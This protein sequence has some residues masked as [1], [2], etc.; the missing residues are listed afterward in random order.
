MPPPLGRACALPAW[1]Q[2]AARAAEAAVEA[3]ADAVAPIVDK[4]DVAWM[5]TST[6]LVLFMII[7]G[8]ALFYGGL[9]R[10]KN[11]LSVLMQTTMITAVVMIIWVFYG[12][13]FAFGG[14]TSPYWGGF[15][16]AVPGGRHARQPS[17]DLHRWRDAA[18]ICVHRLPDDLCGNHP[19]A[20]HRRLCRADQVFGA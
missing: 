14:G 6:L 19:G 11:M 12:Y 1:A 2:D 9:V 4:G 15:G 8:L 18:R 3:V 10:T 13:S 17:R 16:K 20:D 7:P 5:M